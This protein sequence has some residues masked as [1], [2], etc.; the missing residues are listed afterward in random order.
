MQMY[1]NGKV[2]ADVGGAQLRNNKPDL[3]RGHGIREAKL[4][5]KPKPKQRTLA[6][7]SSILAR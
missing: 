1:K 6:L 2:R 3:S 5:L 7:A 4:K